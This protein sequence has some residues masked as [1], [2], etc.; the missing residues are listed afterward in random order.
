[1]IVNTYSPNDVILSIGDYIVTGW[2]SITV[3]RSDVTKMIRGIRGQN[4]RSV[5]L[6]TSCT[7][8]IELLQTST[9]ND[10]FSEIVSQD[11]IKQTGRIELQ[12][13]DT[14]GRSVLQSVNA[15]IS[16]FPDIVYGAE[17]GTRTWIIQCLNAS[18]EVK[19][20]ETPL[21]QTLLNVFK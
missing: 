9:S 17:I 20:N 4:T 16:N 13:K 15:Y 1:M 11:R 12:L 21:L 3:A 5:S 2:N 10:V 18:Y 8:A 19:G 6:D 7:I 14:S